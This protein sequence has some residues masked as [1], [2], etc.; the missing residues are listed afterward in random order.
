[1]HGTLR[2]ILTN[3]VYIGVIYAEGGRVQPSRPKQAFI[4]S[5]MPIKAIPLAMM[6]TGGGQMGDPPHGHK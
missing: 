2:R 6:E 5:I 3:P 4:A 1:M